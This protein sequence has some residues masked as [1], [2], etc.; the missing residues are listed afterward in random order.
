MRIKK[1]LKLILPPIHADPSDIPDSYIQAIRCGERALPQPAYLWSARLAHAVA[2]SGRAE[3]ENGLGTALELHAEIGRL[4]AVAKAGCVAL[5]E[6]IKGKVPIPAL[7]SK[8]LASAGL[9]CGVGDV[10]SIFYQVQED[11]E[12]LLPFECLPLPG[13]SSVLPPV[14]DANGLVYL[15]L[16]RD[17]RKRLD[18]ANTFQMISDG[19][20]S[21]GV[22]GTILDLP[23]YCLLKYGPFRIV[24]SPLPLR[25]A[26][27]EKPQLLLGP[28]VSHKDAAVWRVDNVPG[29]SHLLGLAKSLGF[30]EAP[31]LCKLGGE[32]P[33][34][35]NEMWLLPGSGKV[36]LR[37]PTRLLPLD[38][39]DR[40][41]KR[42][43]P[44]AMEI[45]QYNVA[46]IAHSLAEQLDEVE[47]S[48]LIDAEA[49]RRCMHAHGLG[50]RHLGLVFE[51]IKLPAVKEA[52]AADMMARAS[53]WWL[54]KLQLEKNWEDAAQEVHLGMKN[55]EFDALAAAA[56]RYFSVSKTS[57]VFHIPV[58][59]VF[60]K[61]LIHHC[62]CLFSPSSHPGNV[63]VEITKAILDAYQLS[64]E[65][66][67]DQYFPDG[68]VIFPRVFSLKAPADDVQDDP[69]LLYS[70]ILARE[71]VQL[72]V[73]SALG[74]WSWY[75]SSLGLIAEAYCR[76]ADLETTLGHPLAC[77]DFLKAARITAQA[78]KQ[79]CIEADRAL[80]FSAPNA[81]ALF[82]QYQKTGRP[83]SLHALLVA[84]EICRALYERFHAYD[85]LLPILREI[86]QVSEDMLGLAHS[87]TTSLL[88]RLGQSLEKSGADLD[89]LECV[90]VF[91]KAMNACEQCAELTILKEQQHRRHLDM[92]AF[93]RF[94]LA[95]IRM[96]RSEFS[97][98][99]E[100]IEGCLTSW[101][102]L[103][104]AKHAKTLNAAHLKGRIFEEQT[105][106]LATSANPAAALA[107]A[108]RWRTALEELRVRLVDDDAEETVHNERIKSVATDLIRVEVWS[109]STT[110]LSDAW[111]LI[112]AKCGGSAEVENALPSRHTVAMVV[113]KFVSER[114]PV[115]LTDKTLKLINERAPF[116]QRMHIWQPATVLAACNVALNYSGSIKEWFENLLRFA[117][118]SLGKTGD[119]TSRD[120]LIDIY[121]AL[122]WLPT[123]NGE[124]MMGPIL[125]VAEFN[126]KT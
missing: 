69:K 30:D 89:G 105:A 42:L 87:I 112:A 80:A 76:L 37:G 29:T 23:I 117:T 109:M 108:D 8:R 115:A 78:C 49:V 60:E 56:A 44:E 35:S 99:R 72:A 11:G 28:S 65:C 48:F 64:V 43:R 101:E 124:A 116:R 67:I 85:R 113:E 22:Y 36:C 54:R 1:D 12:Y 40:E 15:V 27:D 84:T 20:W 123:K 92:A 53:K 93:S 52:L 10:D 73:A 81:Q 120:L 86:T 34:G 16:T 121:S 98:A 31:L 126:R 7:D 102:A 74:E 122:C 125:A 107:T 118:G 82:D 58:W 62:Q 9:I 119:F 110:M 61:Y 68:R 57:L 24:V 14:L 51:A 55:S 59:E 91:S 21:R 63:H 45:P 90:K 6:L 66:K 5:T 39:S 70:D 32:A 77:A 33:E 97:E 47:T 18:E 75:D 100:A 46:A 111:D 104:G 38:D 95:G 4:Q 96:N 83:R 13:E 41:G 50:A 3:V 25:T 71:K 26:V 2:L 94:H 88:I 106:S 79:P 19:A 103:H 17:D 114:R